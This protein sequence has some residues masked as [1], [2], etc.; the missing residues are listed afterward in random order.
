MRSHFTLLIAVVV[1]AVLLAY[2]FAFQ[3]RY[4]QVAVVQT[5]GNVE[6]PSTNEAGQIERNDAGNVVEPGSLKFDPGL[7]FKWPWPIQKVTTYSR[8]IHLLEST[9]QQVQTADGNSVVVKT[10]L[11]WRIDNPHAFFSSV[12]NVEEAESKLSALLS[13]VG[14]LVSRDYRFD[15]LVNNN[16]DRLKLDQ[17]ENEFTKWL[18]DRLAQI[19]P[20][21]GVEVEQFGIRRVLLPEDVT[22][23]VLAR[24][25]S[26]REAMAARVRKEAS[27]QAQSITSA[28][29]SHKRQ[30]LAFAEA[31]AQTLRTRGDRRAAQYYDAFAQNEEFAVFLRQ[32]EA[33]E[34]TL[35]HNT[36]FILDAKDLGP[37]NVLS[38]GP[39][40][41][42]QAATDGASPGNKDSKQTSEQAVS[43][44]SSAAQASDQ[45]AP[46]QQ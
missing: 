36:T 15:E 5:F 37:L 30:I 18:Q 11:A 29:E 31:Q 4:D 22:P 42:L 28:A 43:S 35:P 27:A 19:T 44:K 14:G 45:Q 17:L 26:T 23:E 24:M 20:S 38:N 33:L 39:G 1:V 9:L 8:K 13:N 46:S 41:S 3:V 34:K 10:Y 2:M 16:P 40:P 12:G 21:Y 7:Y 6:A 32:I 25:R